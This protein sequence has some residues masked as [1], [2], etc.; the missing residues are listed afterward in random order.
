[1]SNDPTT[2]VDKDNDSENAQEVNDKEQD[3][4]T[5]RSDPKKYSTE[6]TQINNKEILGE[7]NT[8]VNENI[9]QEAEDDDYAK[10]LEKCSVEYRSQVENLPLTN[11]SSETETT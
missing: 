7:K 11:P 3:V 1:M 10:S 4:S 9:T 5:E 8:T 6:E 2:K